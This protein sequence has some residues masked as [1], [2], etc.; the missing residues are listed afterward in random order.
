MKYL[1]K[2]NNILISSFV[3]FRDKQLTRWLGSLPELLCQEIICF[4]TVKIV[5]KIATHA[6]PGFLFGLETWIEAIL[7]MN[8]KPLFFRNF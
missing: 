7:G 3:C 1:R 2:S 6:P 8:I 5:V 4:K